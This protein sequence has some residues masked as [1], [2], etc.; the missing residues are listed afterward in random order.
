MPSEGEALGKLTG[1][2]VAGCPGI[3]QALQNLQGYCPAHHAKRLGLLRCLC[4]SDG[5]EAKLLHKQH[6][7]I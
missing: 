4:A 6:L 5:S 2:A 1:G 3:R 7:Q